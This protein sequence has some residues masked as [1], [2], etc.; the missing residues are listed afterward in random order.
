[1]TDLR[2]MVVMIV[3]MGIMV[4]EMNGIFRNRGQGHGN[5]RDSFHGKGQG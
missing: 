2:I 1:M 4:R 3:R 5:F